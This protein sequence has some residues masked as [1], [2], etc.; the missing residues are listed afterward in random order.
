MILRLF[1]PRIF[2]DDT[3]TNAIYNYMD[4]TFYLNVVMNIVIRRGANSFELCLRLN[5]S[6]VPSTPSLSIPL[7]EGYL[8]SPI[9]L[10]Y[11]HPGQ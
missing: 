4:R 6:L 8:N 9:S 1:V 7:G 10:K 5:S 11:S 3:V 2:Y